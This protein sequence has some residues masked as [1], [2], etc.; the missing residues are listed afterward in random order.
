MEGKILHS[1]GVGH[2]N[3]FPREDVESPPL[4][5]HKTQQN[6]KQPEAALKLAMLGAGDCSPKFP[7][8]QN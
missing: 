6:C 7:S 1:E 5:V 8:T 4:K 2:Q 3:K